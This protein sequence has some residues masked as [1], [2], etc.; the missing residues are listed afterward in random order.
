MIHHWPNDTQARV[1]P[2]KATCGRPKGKAKAEAIVTRGTDEDHAPEAEG[3]EQQP[4]RLRLWSKTTPEPGPDTTTGFVSTHSDATG[5]AQAFLAGPVGPQGPLNLATLAT[6]SNLPHHLAL[7]DGKLS[8]Y[9]CNK[10]QDLQGGEFALRTFARAKCLRIARAS[11]PS[12]PLPLV[13]QR[14]SLGHELFRAGDLTFCNICGKWEVEKAR[15][16]LKIC[17]DSASAPLQLSRLR[18]GLHPQKDLELGR[19]YRA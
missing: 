16:L 18:R 17:P 3:P 11:A 13:P 15:G 12:Q 1:N 19:V 4:I 5:E 9:K 10:T 8:C 14:N 6:H 2:K 7:L